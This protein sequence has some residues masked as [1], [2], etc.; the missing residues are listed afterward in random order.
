MNT[1]DFK[2]R[3]TSQLASL[4]LRRAGG[5]YDMYKLLKILYMIDRE[6]L[7]RWGHPVTYDAPYSMK[8]GPVPSHTYDIIKGVRPGETWNMLFNER[9]P[10]YNIS[11]KTDCLQFDELSEAEIKLAN[12]IF[13]QFGH[14]SGPQLKAI[15]HAFP[16]YEEQD[17]N[18]SRPIDFSLILETAGWDEDEIEEAI[19]DL[20]HQAWFEKTVG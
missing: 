2:E 6:A 14:L 19:R 8:S 18:S 4:I 15:T 11:L 10:S 1:P 12:E 20:A 7:R 13:G 3:K 16:E 5:E 17:G 9:E